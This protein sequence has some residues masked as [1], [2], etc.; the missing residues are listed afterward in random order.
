MRAFIIRGF[1][2]K[3]DSEDHRFDLDAV[4]RDLIQPALAACELTGGTTA[5]IDE[6]G[7]IHADMF[8]LIVEAHV[9][10]CDIT[11]HNANVFY[12][13]GVRHALRKKHTV[14]IKAR[15]SA[16]ATPFDI[17][18]D[19]YLAYDP[20]D[21]GA[22][23]ADLVKRINGG[24]HSAR[25]TD[26]PIFQVLT[27]L[28]EADRSQVAVV[29][30]DFAAEVARA[31]S[32][33]SRG[34]LRLLSQEVRGLRFGAEG[35]GVIGAA[36]S[37][38]NDLEGAMQTWEAV[39]ERKPQDLDANLELATLYERW[40]GRTAD[41]VFLERSNEAIR[42]VLAVDALDAKHR[43]EALALQA[44]NLKTLW[45]T[46]LEPMATVAERRAAAL[47]RYLLQAYEVYRSA[48]R[49]SLNK[50]Y[51]GITTLQMGALLQDLSG[52][53]RWRNLF[54][55]TI[56][57]A[58][59]Q[60]DLVRELA[61]LHPIV[62]LAC[63]AVEDRGEAD[64]EG[65]WARITLADLDF[66]ESPPEPSAGDIASLCAGYAEA[67]R[68]AP[69]FARDS[70]RRQLQL[71]AD[72]DFRSPAAKAILETLGAQAGGGPGSSAPQAGTAQRTHLVVFSGHTVD[73]P[74]T[75][76][77]RFP[78]AAEAAVRALLE[79]R[80]RELAADGNGLTV[81]ASAA[82]GADILAIE[83][84]RALGV[85][86]VLCLPMPAPVVAREV[87]GPYA[88]WLNR[89]QD[90]V[91]A[92]QDR[93]LV[94]HD[95]ARLPDWLQAAGTDPW[96]R[97][98]RWMV[99]LAQA[100]GADRLTLLAFWDGNESDLS[101]GGTAEMVRLARASGRF[102]IDVIDARSVPGP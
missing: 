36:Q 40:H 83:A 17:G 61:V 6:P 94:L 86:S 76:P 42:T 25:E 9:V 80:L 77:P 69:T 49:A 58:R 10:V 78:A 64:P 37:R 95:Q 84:C 56:E 92:A 16:D 88:S 59:F 91:E 74:G 99:E 29:P 101:H 66:L 70:A 55:T 102:R 71:F 65:V 85:P 79:K 98:N 21:P 11:V 89:F 34:W 100:W 46:E 32:A 51:A 27:H 3:K 23:V 93:R 50:F 13:L 8:A 24:L 22:S 26:S 53:A 63:E 2:T 43:S 28:D 81:L 96:A 39:R 35:L 54:R 52:Q 15:G 75:A 14:L 67:L 20:A 62:R 73:L 57:A 82:P 38:I 41:R 1:G 30:A 12:E 60:E 48:F 31:E 44:R 7:S 97:G 45:R 19:R 87:F 72:L 5:E 68:G 33:Q 90:V 18:G 47:N 4:E